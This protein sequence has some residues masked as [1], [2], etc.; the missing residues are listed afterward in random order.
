M[1]RRAAHRRTGRGFT[2]VELLIA[3]LMSALVLLSVYFVF[4]ANTTQYYRQEQIVQMQESMRFAV[5]LMKNDLRNAGRL[6]IVR[7]DG[8]GRDP[9]LCTE[10][11]GSRAVQLFEDE[12]D[13]PDVLTRLQNGLSPDRVRLTVDAGAAIMMRTRQVTPDQIVLAPAVEQP[14]TEA[15][16]VAASEQRFRAQFRAGM[17]VSVSAPGNAF[18]MVPIADVGFAAAGSTITLSQPVCPDNRIR[19]CGQSCLVGVAQLVEYAVVEHEDDETR[20]DLLRRVIDAR[21]G[22]TPLE[23]LSLT[24]AEYVVD[25]QV[26]GLDR[27]AAA[28]SMV[29]EQERDPAREDVEGAQAFENIQSLRGLGVLLAARTPR[30]DAE[31]V[32]APDRAVPVNDR[33]ASERAWFDVSDAPGSGLARVATLKAQVEATN[34]YR[35]ELDVIE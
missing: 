8:Q 14:T 9:R 16:A 29:N 21:N 3:G 5:E 10:R 15:R 1:T 32:V 19:T 11:L 12:P 27:D 28:T 4:I 31:F 7:G 20:T 22:R 2:L 13:V 24:V 6:A 26:W 23:G 35:G 17:Y 34:L 30:E 33:R 25:L 18:D